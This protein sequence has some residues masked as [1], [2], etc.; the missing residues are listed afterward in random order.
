[1][2]SLQKKIVKGK[3]YW[4]IIESKRVDGKPTPIVL[5]YIGN[6]KRLYERLQQSNSINN[7]TLKSYSHGDTY[8]L[9]TIARKLNLE[10]LLDETIKKQVKDGIKRST[11]LILAAIQRV[12]NPG[13]K[14]E[15]AEW[16]KTTTL[17][18]EMGIKPE[19]MTSQ[20]F[21]KQMD[22]ITEEELIQAEDS[23]SNMILSMYNIELE[24]LALDYTNY[25]TFISA[26]N[27]CEL[28]K[29]GRNKQKRHDLKQCSLAIVTTKEAG[30][31]LFSHVYAGNI[32][33]QT[34]FKEYMSLLE[35]RLPNCNLDEIT[36]I[37]DGGSNTKKNLSSLKTHYI[38]S[39]S[40]AYCKELY[41]IDINSY[42]NIEVNGK[43]VKCHRVIKNIWDKNRTCILTFSQGLYNGQVAELDANIEKVIKELDEL[44]LKI[45]NKNSRIKKS[46]EAITDRV[47]KVISK[48]EYVSEIFDIEINNNGVTHTINNS[49]KQKLMTL[50]FGKKL[51]ITDRGNWSTEEIVKAY[52]EQ[53]CI[54][55]I[56]KDTKSIKHFS[57]RPIYHWTEQKIRVHIFI[58]LLGLTITSILQKELHKCDIDISKNMLI[59]TLSNIRQCWVKDKNSNKVSKVLEDMDELQTN[60]LN[61]VSSII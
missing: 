24:K 49:N 61:A 6:T 11:S 9:M 4:S 30:I 50:Y 5:D 44:N 41:D 59:E 52:Y 1:M 54:E 29:R 55:K 8:S 16:F 37:F 34:E 53:D 40:I 32:N 60:L 51:T 38:C 58:C 20:H 22:S 46:I 27:T 36:L 13:S 31:P 48:Y 3:E 2:A 10:E 17:P 45:N 18:Y 57:L 12:C 33:D 19:V 26:D 23:I 7:I 43:M 56:F 35:Q 25:F 15:F 47:G 14:N 21:W 42:E 28:T 39:F